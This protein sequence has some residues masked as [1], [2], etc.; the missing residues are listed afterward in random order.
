MVEVPK[1][2]YASDLNSDPRPIPSQNTRK[3]GDLDSNTSCHFIL[4]THTC[5]I[6]TNVSSNDANQ[7]ETK[8]VSKRGPYHF[9]QATS[10]HSLRR[11]SLHKPSPLAYAHI[12]ILTGCGHAMCVR[13][14]SLARL[15]NQIA[16]REFKATACAR[17]S[18]SCTSQLSLCKFTQFCGVGNCRLEREGERGQCLR[19]RQVC[20]MMSDDELTFRGWLVGCCIR[21]LAVCAPIA[22]L[23][24]RGM[25]GEFNHVSGV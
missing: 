13:A 10:E 15:R 25:F 16:F 23:L 24:L 18:L 8:A 11:P 17:A 4:L 3:Y 6:N 2:S 5:V 14:R 20:E 22:K 21:W 12:S 19:A 1:K 9:L 7:N